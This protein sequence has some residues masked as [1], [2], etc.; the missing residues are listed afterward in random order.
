MT[1]PN[2]FYEAWWWLQ[3]HPKFY[4]PEFNTPG[5]FETL[6]ISVQKVDPETRRIEDD[7]SRNTRVEIWLEAGPY[8]VIQGDEVDLYGD[9]V[10]HSHDYDLDCGGATYEEAILKMAKLV[11]KHHG[12]Y[13]ASVS[14]G[15]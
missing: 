7:K 8:H 1:D 5:F 13:D 12:D 11:K 3:N 15:S 6:D 9:G 14:S 4:H 10:A 2:E